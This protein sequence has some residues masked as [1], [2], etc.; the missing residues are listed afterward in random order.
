MP[1]FFLVGVDFIVFLALIQI[2][3]RP[4]PP[5]KGSAVY[6]TIEYW[7]DSDLHCNCCGPVQGVRVPGRGGGVGTLIFSAYI[8]SGPATTVHPK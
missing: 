1:N 4:H 7:A 2:L 3:S 5:H 8:G 6:L